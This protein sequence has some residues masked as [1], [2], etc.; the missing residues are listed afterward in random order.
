MNFFRGFLIALGL[1]IPVWIFIWVAI[2]NVLQTMKG[3]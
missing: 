3:F 2:V 1:S